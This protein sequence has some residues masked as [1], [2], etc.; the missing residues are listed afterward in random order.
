MN[1]AGRKPWSVGSVVALA[2][3]LVCAGVLGSGML[4]LLELADDDDC[5][6]TGKRLE[7]I[8]SLDVLHSPPAGARP[9]KGFEEADTGCLDDSGDEYLGSLRAYDSELDEA[10]VLKHYRAVAKGG[11]WK[12][13]KVT[14]GTA[15]SPEDVDAVKACFTKDMP[16]GAARLSLRHDP[17]RTFQVNVESDLDGNGLDC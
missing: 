7:R 6:G 12:E 8:A 13:R 15:E 16:G 9:A 10:T 1:T 11:G 14:Y 2:A 3:G 17:S 5:E 4:T